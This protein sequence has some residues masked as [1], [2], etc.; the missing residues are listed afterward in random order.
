MDTTTVV[1]PK[2][3]LTQDRYGYLHMALEPATHKQVRRAGALA[4]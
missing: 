2:A 4:Q 3:K 1:P